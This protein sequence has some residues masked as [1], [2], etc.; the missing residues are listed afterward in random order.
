MLRVLRILELAEESSTPAEHY[1]R[2]TYFR[3]LQNYKH[4]SS[5]VK[6]NVSAA[7][8]KASGPCGPKEAKAKI[9]SGSLSNFDKKKSAKV[10]GSS[11]E[12]KSQKTS[13]TVAVKRKGRKKKE[14]NLAK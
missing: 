12:E 3:H 14:V 7:K 5:P 6:E 4:D 13:K 11:I 9:N 8:K 1:A 2:L 10:D